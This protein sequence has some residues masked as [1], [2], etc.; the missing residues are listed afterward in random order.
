MLKGK[1][2]EIRPL[3]NTFFEHFAMMREEDFYMIER[4]A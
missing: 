2:L 1:M 3:Q 4:D